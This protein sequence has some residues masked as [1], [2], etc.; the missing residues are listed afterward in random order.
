MQQLMSKIEILLKEYE[1]VRKG[2]L[3]RPLQYD[4]DREAERTEALMAKAKEIWGR[5]G[6]SSGTE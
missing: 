6:I 3:H 1:P 2:L 4:K 5:Y